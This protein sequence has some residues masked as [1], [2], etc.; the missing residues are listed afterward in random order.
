MKKKKLP[1]PKKLVLVKESLH[2]LNATLGAVN[3]PTGPICT[4][5]RTCTC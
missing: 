1:R 2:A 3:G 4:R 5:Y